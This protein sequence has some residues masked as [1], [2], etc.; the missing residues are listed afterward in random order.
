VPGTKECCLL[1]LKERGSLRCCLLLGSKLKVILKKD[2]A[3]LGKA[4]EV[5][6]VKDGF[7]RNFLLPKGFALPATA[8]NLK[9]VQ[10]E[11][12]KQALRQEQAKTEAESLAQKITASS[13]TITVQAGTDG[14]LYGSVTSQDIVQA[15]KTEGINI[16]KRKI[17]LPEAIKEVGVFKINVRLHPE[18]TAEGKLWVVKE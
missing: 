4:G 14:K 11:E 13:C 12:K 15:Y 17:E 2:I 1:R 9:V 6:S 3:K 10:Q 8:L 5:V 18:V 7:G 16:D